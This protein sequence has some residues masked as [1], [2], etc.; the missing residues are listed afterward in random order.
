MNPYSVLG[1]SS[2]ASKEDA[3]KRYRE[4]AKKYHPDSATGDAVKFNEVKKA[5]EMIEKGTVKPL[6]K[7]GSFIHK[8]VFTVVKV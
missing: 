5:Y 6:I 4:L 7:K 3:K 8:T 2:M 1:L